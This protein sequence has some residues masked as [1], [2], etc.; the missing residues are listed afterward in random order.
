MSY[1]VAQNTSFLTIAS[2][3][4]K[5]ISSVYFIIIARTIGTHNNGDYF[6]IITSIA[7]FTV[8]ADFGIT[9]VLTREVSKYPE[10]TEQYFQT[11]FYTK[12]IFGLA[13]LGLIYLSKIAFNYPSQPFPLIVL[14][15]CTM[16]FD[17]LQ[18]VFYGTLRS[19][20][21]LLFEAIGIICSQTLTLIIGT[22]VILNHWP[23]MWLIA[24]YTIPSFIINFYSA[25]C[26]RIRYRISLIPRF[27][28]QVFKTLIALAWPFALAGII[29]RFFSY[30]DS[31]IMNSFLT[32]H[33]IGVWGA[34]YKIAAA[35]QFIPITLSVSVFP[36]MS[37]LV[38]IDI[39]KI[40]ELYKRSFHYLLLVAFPLGLGTIALAEPLVLK[41]L[42][43]DFQESIPVLQLLMISLILGFLSFINGAVLN[44]LGKQK[45]Q[46]TLMFYTLLI[47]SRM[48]H[49]GINYMNSL[50]RIE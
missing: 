36:A 46:T 19:K 7:I 40:K 47:M 33:E 25:L 37:S 22:I 28:K 2:I 35:F 32:P 38:T 50:V 30:N 42:K 14:A 10:K 9:A 48:V 21:N 12:F 3:L 4:Q 45:V 13:T 43:T 26:L 17:N 41:F 49:I 5:V 1:T 15:G 6:T 44:S 27:D 29:S 8:I 18:M 11:A 31:I 24:A 23:L 34:A 39:E 16:F 20:K